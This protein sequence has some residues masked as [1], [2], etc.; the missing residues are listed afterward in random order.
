MGIPT[1]RW[2]TSLNVEIEKRSGERRLDKLRTIHLFEADFN[3]GTKLIFNKRMLRNARDHVLIPDPQYQRKGA[4]SVEA[5]I[6]K[7]LF[8]DLLRLQQ[9]PGS[10]VSNDLRSC[11]DRNPHPVGSIACRRLGVNPPQNSSCC[12]DIPIELWKRGDPWDK[13][14]SRRKQLSPI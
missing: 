3:T 9:R 8:F 13:S 5:I 4:R 7:R 1:E 6:F 12:K 11:F 2:T 10:V 14:R